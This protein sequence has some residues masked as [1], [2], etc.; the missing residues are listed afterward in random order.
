VGENCLGSQ[1]KSFTLVRPLF[2][3]TNSSQPLENNGKG[4]KNI[5]KTLRIHIYA[6]CTM[7]GF[8]AYMAKKP[9]LSGDPVPLNLQN[10]LHALKFRKN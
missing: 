4:I 9:F 10:L 7:H 3:I 5:Q 6:M 2:Q 8:G 1:L